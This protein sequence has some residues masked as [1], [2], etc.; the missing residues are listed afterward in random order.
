MTTPERD[1]I[2][3]ELVLPGNAREEAAE[4]VRVARE[5]H[6]ADLTLEERQIPGPYQ[7]PDRFGAAFLP[8]IPI[9]IAGA[10][11]VLALT[12]MIC[13]LR[14][15]SIIDLRGGKVKAIKECDA[16]QHGVTIVVKPDGSIE[17]VRCEKL[18]DMIKAAL[19]GS[20]K[21][22]GSGEKKATSGSRD[23]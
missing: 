5:Q 22:S 10:I 7:D 23:S 13:R 19:G 20:D 12:E 6:N 21:Q 1:A 8:L 15:G 17:A 9:V 2:A 14:C 16:V 4:I 11:G 18:S 3:F